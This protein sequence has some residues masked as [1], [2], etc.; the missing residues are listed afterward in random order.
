[1][2]RDGDHEVPLG[3]YEGD[4]MDLRGGGRLYPREIIHRFYDKDENVLMLD[5]HIDTIGST[6]RPDVLM[7]HTVEGLVSTLVKNPGE[8][9]AWGVDGNGVVRVGVL[10]H[11]ALSGAI[12]RENEQTPWRTI[13]PLQNRHGTMQPLGFD[14]ANERLFVAALTVGL[15]VLV[16]VYGRR[17]KAG[18]RSHTQSITIGLL[19]T[20]VAQ[21][22]LQEY[23]FRM[24]AAVQKMVDAQVHN[25]RQ[26]YERII[27]QASYLVNLDR[28]IFVAVLIWW[29]V[30]LWRDE[31]GAAEQAAAEPDSTPNQ[32]PPQSA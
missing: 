19:V 17:F 9:R 14:A 22:S 15:G 2:D 13:L 20:A 7:V 4:Q 32:E 8:V 1:M 11:G 31:P 5:R 26:E 28:V 12:Y 30:W 29:I 27:H 16:L 18:W 6:N 24:Q 23:F 21:L 3:G 25:V 10:S